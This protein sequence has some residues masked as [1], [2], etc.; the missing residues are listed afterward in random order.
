MLRKL[1]IIPILSMSVY[2]MNC[3]DAKSNI[4]MKQCVTKNYQ[5]LNK[6]LN[7]VYNNLLKELDDTG[8]KK[9]EQSQKAWLKFRENQAT[10]SAD[11]ARGSLASGLYYID[12]ATRLT[13]Q[14]IQDLESTLSSLEN[15]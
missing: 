11:F 4:E 7:Y 12:E 13:K 9:L 10:F 14:R 3:D 15:M 1:L 8:K 6:K 5:I 2:A